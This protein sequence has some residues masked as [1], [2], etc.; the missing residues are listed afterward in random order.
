MEVQGVVT[1]VVTDLELEA[2]LEDVY[3]IGE[4]NENEE[5]NMAELGKCFKGIP[6]RGIAS[7]NFHSF[8]QKRILF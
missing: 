6:G 7:Y 2:Q 8:Y 3:P 1:E 4:E 5:D